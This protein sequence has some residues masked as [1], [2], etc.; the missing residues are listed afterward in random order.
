[1]ADYFI[2]HHGQAGVGRGPVHRRESPVDRSIT[3]G[4]TGVNAPLE[5]M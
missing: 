2:N 3:S 4:D 5:C 1:M